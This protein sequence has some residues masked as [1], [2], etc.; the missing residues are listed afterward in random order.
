[1]YWSTGP[2]WRQLGSSFELL[3]AENVKA[4][5]A[6]LVVTFGSIKVCFALLVPALWIPA[7]G[8]PRENWERESL[9]SWRFLVFFFLFFHWWEIA[10]QQLSNLS[11]SQSKSYSRAEAESKSKKTHRFLFWPRFSIQAALIINLQTTKKKKLHQENQ[12][13]PQ[14]RK[15]CGRECKKTLQVNLQVRSLNTYYAGW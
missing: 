5:L 14:T 3:A 8:Y 9:R 15:H 12:S 2:L 6:I 1:M 7:A 10:T 4:F 11:G 13:R